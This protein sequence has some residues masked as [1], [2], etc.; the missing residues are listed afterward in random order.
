M[1]SQAY[2]NARTMMCET[3][4]RA[5]TVRYLIDPSRD[6]T[7]QRCIQNEV[8]NGFLLVPTFV[9]IL[10][11]R[12]QE[13]DRYPTMDDF[14]PEIVK[15]VNEYEAPNY[16]GSG[17]YDEYTYSS[18]TNLLP[19]V[20]SVSPSR[21]VQF[22]KGNL[23]WDGALWH[24]EANQ[25]N[26]P[27][28]WDPEHVGHFFWTTDAADAVAERF[29]S[30]IYNTATTSDHLFCDGSDAAHSLSVDGLSG[31][32]VLGDGENGE[33]DYL[34]NKRQ[35]AVNLYR[36]PVSIKGVGNCLILAPDG[37][38]GTINSSYNAE[39]WAEAEAAGLVCL[40]TA[41]I[42]WSGAV[43]DTDGFKGRYWTGTPKIDSVRH[44]H[45]LSIIGSLHRY[46]SYS[47]RSAGFSIRLVKDVVE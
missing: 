8:S 13:R 17:Q 28:I 43:S 19:G 12:E 23:C 14:M 27:N 35:N 3:F 6:K 29:K 15:A 34:L 31:L 39:T 42:R 11:K 5:S 18:T 45:M 46:P 4:V 30:S 21:K 38:S 24:F 47:S 2:G 20:F 36:Y 10:D 22:T 37:Y 32:R 40:T 26:Y 16:T 7:Q 33:I 1:R 25:M 44:A 9:D 41:G